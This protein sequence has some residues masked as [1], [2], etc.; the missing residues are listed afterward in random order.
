MKSIPELHTLIEKELKE[1][2]IP[3]SPENLYNP[4]EYVLSIGVTPQKVYCRGESLYVV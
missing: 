4:I 2:K 3:N 1:I